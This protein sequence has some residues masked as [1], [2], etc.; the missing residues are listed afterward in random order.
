LK[1]ANVLINCDAA[2]QLQPHLTDFGL[3]RRVTGE[4]T[5]TAD[6]Q[7]MGTPAYMSPEQASGGGHA[8]GPAS[9][10]YSLGVIL[11]ELL[12]GE[13]PFRGAPT[14]VIDQVLNDEPVSPRRLNAHVPRDLET[15]TLKC[16][17]K[18][19]AKRYATAAAVAN[20]LASWQRGEPIVARP[21]GRFAR[22]YRWG[23]RHPLVTAAGLA[24]IIGG[25]AI[26][27]VMTAL[28]WR[29]ATARQ[30]ADSAREQTRQ[31][32]YASSMN[33]VQ[34]AVEHGDMIRAEQF[35]LSTRPAVGE[36]DLRSFE[37]YHWWRQAH[38]GLAA[39]I[40]LPELYKV[41]TTD[42]NDSRLLGALSPPGSGMGGSLKAISLS[43]ALSRES[44]VSLVEQEFPISAQS[45]HNEQMMD[46]ALS[47]DESLL[48]TC[49][50]DGTVQLWDA[51]SGAQRATLR[52]EPNCPFAC[53]DVSPQGTLVVA[54]SGVPTLRVNGNNGSKADVYV[55]N[56]TTQEVMRH[57][58][59]SDA[60][61]AHATISPDGNLIAVSGSIDVV[62]FNVETGE[63][64]VLASPG[65]LVSGCGFSPD[66]RQLAGMIPDGKEICLWDLDTGE[67]RKKLSPHPTGQIVKFCRN[68]NQLI[69]VGFNGSLKLWNVGQDSGPR[70][71]TEESAVFHLAFGAD[72]RRLVADSQRQAGVWDVSTSQRVR[73]LDKLGPGNHRVSLSN[74]GSVIA[75]PA[76]QDVLLYSADSGQLLQTCRGHVYPVLK[77]QIAP[78]GAL[79][80]SGDG[81]RT[82]DP[83]I[84]LADAI[85]WDAKSGR[86][87]HRL[88]GHYQRVQA[89]AFSPDERTLVTVDGHNWLRTWD[90]ATGKLLRASGERESG[91]V[92]REWAGS[93]LSGLFQLVF[94]RDGESLYA[95]AAQTMTVVDATTGTLRRKLAFG[96]LR[97]GDFS[98]SP[99]D[100]TLAVA[101][102]RYLT[103]LT[104]A[105]GVVELWD[106]ASGELKTT[107]AREYGEAMAVVFSPDGRTLATGH[108]NG[109][110]A[111]WQAASEEEVRRQAP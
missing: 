32:L 82:F 10:V 24:L 34:A 15:I 88:P 90:V 46:A 7:L 96:D 66:G 83:R 59:V 72:G 17:E 62:L 98:L 64:S 21:L 3:A 93:E 85:L 99:D 56:A 95:C 110:I 78:S 29:E 13:P 55:W 67:I 54:T 18:D 9:D 8:A 14:M 75:A 60:P 49:G 81:N 22:T 30:A 87:L 63:K 48:A 33:N 20:D 41:T 47:E 5:M 65:Q 4:L 97:I 76:G 6:G 106:V 26:G 40:Q 71:I 44:L 84:P 51:N 61:Y 69:S 11:Y 101:R 89:L 107:L 31:V 1:P 92:G 12:A 16:L 39:T 45:A 37:W 28:A 36:E 25:P 94:D 2:G 27:L 74:D 42:L 77:C 70:R 100:K 109:T 68:S 79:V 57:W 91:E 43:L 105:E 86:L 108:R 111:L 50:W 73:A 52:G 104:S 19:P 58:E 35:L 103:R 53:V 102:G 23:R 38:A 80:A